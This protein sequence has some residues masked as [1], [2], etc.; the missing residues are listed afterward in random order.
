[1]E[2]GVQLGRIGSGSEHQECEKIGYGRVGEAEKERERS[3]IRVGQVGERAILIWRFL[4]QPQ[5]A[6]ELRRGSC[7]MTTSAKLVSERDVALKV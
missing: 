6:G 1:M 5:F 3:C 2:I 4:H 7:T